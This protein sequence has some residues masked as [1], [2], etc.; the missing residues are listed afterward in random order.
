[1]SGVV[2]VIIC[3]APGDPVRTM[4]GF[5][6]ADANVAELRKRPGLD[7]SLFTQYVVWIGNLLQGDLGQD[8]DSNAPLSELLAQRLPVTF[9]LTGPILL[10]VASSV[11]LGVWAA[12][13]GS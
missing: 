11:P 3:L 5:Q 9:E 10:A 6:A 2:L 1:M 4:L 8:I 13:G 12:N 7:Q